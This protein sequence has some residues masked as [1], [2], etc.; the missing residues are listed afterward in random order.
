MCLLLRCHSKLAADEDAGP[1]VPTLSRGFFFK[2]NKNLTYPARC[3]VTAPMKGCLKLFSVMYVSLSFE[4]IAYTDINVQQAG[5]SHDSAALTALF[6][7]SSES[8]PVLPAVT[9]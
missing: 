7:Y 1:T 2:S 9:S 3:F 5:I 6:T 8:F 4:D